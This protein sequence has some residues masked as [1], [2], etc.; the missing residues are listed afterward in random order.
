MKKKKIHEIF[1]LEVYSKE[2][3]CPC[4]EDLRKSSHCHKI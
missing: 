1:C 3:Y 2:L 4:N